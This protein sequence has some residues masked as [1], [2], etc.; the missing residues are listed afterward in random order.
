[1]ISSPSPWIPTLILLLLSLPIIFFFTSR[2]LPPPPPPISLPDELDD[3]TLFRRAAA[4]ESHPTRRPKSR[5]GFTNSKPK[6]AFLFL[7]N[8]DLQFA[9]LWEKFFNPNKSQSQKSQNRNLYNVYV[10]ADPTVKP[11][12]KPPGGVFSQNRFIPAKQTH[13]GTATLIAAARRLIATAIIDDPANQF[14]TLIS[15]HCI[16]LHSF[17]FLYNTLFETKS[18]QLAELKNLKYKSFIEIISQDPNLWDRYTARGDNVMVPE[19]KFESFRVGSQFFTLTREHALMVVNERRLWK[20][21]RL[22]CLRPQSCYPE[23]HYFPTFLSNEDPKGCAGYT[24]TRVNWTD[25]VNGHPHTYFP[26]E[27]SPELIYS[28]RRS[29]FAQP[30]MFARKFSPACL[31]LL[32]DMADEVIFRD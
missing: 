3:L 19:V 31:N 15:Q 1:M 24:L 18:H 17:Q 29:S 16:P 11:G 28:L 8:T 27:V 4:A 14:F 25:S 22:P 30:Y 23:E 7:T 26:S 5:L 10:H 2:I 12:I 21:F 20:K 13:R 6:I 9:P 32:M